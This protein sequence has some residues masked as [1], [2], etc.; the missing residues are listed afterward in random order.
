MVLK[1]PLPVNPDFLYL[2][3]SLSLFCIAKIISASNQ[4]LECVFTR[5]FSIR[6]IES[7]LFI[8]LFI[9]SECAALTQVYFKW[10]RK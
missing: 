6:A 4:G 9:K 8:N 7:I 10:S 5:T 1:L 3:Y 2:E